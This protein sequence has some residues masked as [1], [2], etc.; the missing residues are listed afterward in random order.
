MR[1]PGISEQP[2]DLRIKPVVR[3]STLPVNLRAVSADLPRDSNSPHVSALDDLPYHPSDPHERL[4]SLKSICGNPT[5]CSNH[6]YMRW[7][8]DPQDD[9]T[10]SHNASIEPKPKCTHC[11]VIMQSP[12]RLSPLQTANSSHNA[13]L[14][15]PYPAQYLI[16]TLPVEPRKGF[17]IEQ[18]DQRYQNQDVHN[19]APPRLARQLGVRTKQPFSGPLSEGDRTP[20]VSVRTIAAH[21]SPKIPQMCQHT[22]YGDHLA[23]RVIHAETM[24]STDMS[25]SCNYQRISPPPFTQ[26][27][28]T[29]AEPMLRAQPFFLD[30]ATGTAPPFAVPDNH[31]IVATRQDVW[32]T[33]ARPP[34]SAAVAQA[35]P[36]VP[37][38]RKSLVRTRLTPTLTSHQP[39]ALEAQLLDEMRGLRAAFDKLLMEKGGSGKL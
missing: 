30:N 12:V 29:E 4:R 17:G 27:R 36:S 16:K 21:P 14:A 8:L 10:L 2:S 23:S 39:S 19:T 5:N 25:T 35:T 32:A 13:R 20:Q 38:H 34:R 33:I 24:S 31:P 9:S 6:L 3:A 1:A 7:Q 28:P 18:P 11:A 37:K 15:G 26:L 22:K